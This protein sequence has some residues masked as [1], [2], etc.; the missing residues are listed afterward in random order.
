MAE[1]TIEWTS[2]AQGELGYSFN[3]WIGCSA[4]S[5]ERTGGGGCDNCYA[6]AQDQFRHWTLEGWGS[7]KPRHRTSVWNWKQPAKWNAAAAK[8]QERRKVFCF[9]LADWLDNEVPIEWLV[10]FLQLCQSTPSLDK[11]LLTKRI[12]NW[13]PRLQ[14]ALDWINIQEPTPR[15]AALAR[16]IED[17]LGGEAPGDVWLGISVVNQKE[18]DR[19]IEKLQATPARLRFLSMEPLLGA[20]DLLRAGAFARGQHRPNRPQIDWA[21]IG[22][23]SGNN[24]RSMALGHA[25]D[26]VRQCQRAGVPVFV[27]Q[28]GARPI[29]RQE[30]PHAITDRKGGLL[31]DWP[32]SLRVRQFPA[33]R[34]TVHA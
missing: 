15:F 29:V 22:G 17:W 32:A 6:Q 3:A 27:K 14:E 33:P 5:I 23:E 2:G 11:L 19:D 34:E 10:D 8:A 18:A 21:I 20:V 30:T 25:E 12:G 9:S 24:A 28:L 4:V 13:R 31:A 1:T 26:L 16:W 7:G